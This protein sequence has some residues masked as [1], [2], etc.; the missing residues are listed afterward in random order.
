MENNRPP[1]LGVFGRTSGQVRL[2]VCENTKQN[3]LQPE[4]E[5][6]TQQESALY[7][8]ENSAYQGIPE[9]GRSHATVCNAQGE[10]ARDDDRDGVREVHCN[11]LEGIWTGLCNFLRPFRGVHKEYL[12][13]YVAIFEWEYNIKRVTFDFL[14][15]IMIP[16]CTYLPT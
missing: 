14:K 1:I 2:K 12:A 15:A 10:W 16:N 8:N 13:Q 4:I 11:T 6:A 9:T 3:T 5:Q 7:T